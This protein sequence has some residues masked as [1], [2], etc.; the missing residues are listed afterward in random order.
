MELPKQF[1]AGLVGYHYQQLTGD[2]GSGAVLGDFKGRVTAIGPAINYDFQ[3]GMLPV[4]TTLKWTHEFGAENR[5][6]GDVA[7]FTVLIP[8]GAPPAPPPK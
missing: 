2:S 7:M 8:L 1:A 3:L 4:S 6:K 5:L